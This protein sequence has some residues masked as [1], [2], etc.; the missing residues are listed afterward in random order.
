MN[1]IGIGCGADANPLVLNEIAD[2]ILMMGESELDFRRLFQWISSSLSVTSQAIGAPGVEA[3]SLAKIPAETFSAPR[4][5]SAPRSNKCAARR[6]CF[7][8]CV[9]ATRARRF[10]C[11]T[12]STPNRAFTPPIARTL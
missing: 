11:A 10:W 4:F 5:R 9:A 3:I 8:R 2:S 1:I 12:V 6:N 7:C